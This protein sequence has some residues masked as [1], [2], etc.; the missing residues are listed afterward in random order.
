MSNDA[1]TT[2]LPAPGVTFD[3]MMLLPESPPPA[4]MLPASTVR[5][6]CT[7]NRSVSVICSVP[8]KFA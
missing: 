1:V 5:F 8:S 3:Q 2:P 4:E 7:G 6:V